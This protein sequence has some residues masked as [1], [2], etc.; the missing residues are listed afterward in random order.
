MVL[1][2]SAIAATIAASGTLFEGVLAALATAAA[3]NKNDQVPPAAVLWPDKERQW[4]TLVARLA[5]RLPILTLGPY[6]PTTRRGPAIWIRAMLARA[7]PTDVLKAGDIPVIYLPG[8]AREEVRAV[9]SCARFLQPLAELQYR[10]VLWNQRNNRDWTIAAFLQSRDGGLG[11]DVGADSAT[12]EA[13][14][15]ALPKLAD[16]PLAHLRRQ[17]PIRAAFLDSLLQPDEAR[18][19][20]RWLDNPETFRATCS[21]AEWAAFVGRCEAAYGF[22]PEKESPVGAARRLAERKGS[23]K[24]VWERFCEAPHAYPRVPEILRGAKPTKPLTLF[25]TDLQEVW[26]QD[27]ERAEDLL[28]EALNNLATSTPN[29]ARDQVAG[30]AAEHAPRTKWVWRQL[31][32]D[33]LALSLEALADVAQQTRQRLDGTSTDAMARA[34]VDR[35]WRADDAALRALAAVKPGPDQDAVRVAL[36]AVYWPWLE[37]VATS[38][39]RAATAPGGYRAGASVPIEKGTV[40]L[41]SDGLRLDAAQRVAEAVRARGLHADLSWRLTALPSIT[42]TAKPAL[43][44]VQARFGTGDG[45]TP[46]EVASGTDVSVEV[47]RRALIW[48][49]IQILRGDELGDPTTGGAWTEGADIDDYGHSYGIKLATYL[50]GEVEVLTIRAA[51]LLEHGWQKVIVTTDHGWL[52]MPGGLPKRDLSVHLTEVRKGRCARLKPGATTSD[53]VAPW[54][55]DS[56]VMFA[57]A[58]GL[59][60]YEAG[61]EYE[62]G[63]LSPQECVTPVLTITRGAAQRVACTIKEIGWK[64]LRCVVKTEGDSTGVRADLRTHAADPSTTIVQSGAKSLSTDGTVSLAVPDDDREGSAAH[65]VLVDSGGGVLAQQLVTVGG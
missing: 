44:P 41:F 64:G 30:L 59:H 5:S 27:T 18:S 6:D 21:E 32:L 1:S 42:D 38:F 57:F 39:Q 51:E 10:G 49:G 24:I 43:A 37:S 31:G 9:E 34:Y 4:E 19:L 47:L 45:I 60:A 65:L 40:L 13:S 25:L 3:Y 12:R 56:S 2:T 8:V 15:R 63:G 26:P 17:A 48:E 7:V 46:K 58:P 29:A 36:R 52:L 28:R 50:V 20:L 35:G 33:P 61:R 53:P 55:W 54:H 23:W 62:H 11:I 16:E 22:H 14:V